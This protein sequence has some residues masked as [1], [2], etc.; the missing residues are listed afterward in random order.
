MKQKSR[1]KRFTING[2]SFTLVICF[3]FF[4][5]WKYCSSSASYV[6]IFIK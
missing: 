6:R 4:T 1:L 3:C 2:C 5:D